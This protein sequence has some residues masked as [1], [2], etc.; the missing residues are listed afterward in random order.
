[1]KKLVYGAALAAALAAPALAN[2]ETD[3]ALNLGYE[4]ADYSSG[5]DYD[6]W[7]IGGVV[8]H[9]LSGG[10]TVQADGQTMLQQWNSGDYSHGYAAAHLST[11]LGGWDLGGFVGLLNYYGDGG[12]LFGVE[13]RT[14]FGNLSLDGALSF[15]DF[16]DNDYNA[17][18]LRV[19]GAYF[20][21]PN[22]AVTAGGARTDIDSFTDYEVTEYSVGAAYQFANNIALSGSYTD[23]DYEFY[24][25]D[26]IQLGLT[27]NFGG[28]SLQDNTNDGAWTSARHVSNTWSRW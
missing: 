19:G 23:A 24:D 2:A 15:S 28:G 18:A 8:T 26:A 6:G 25:V 10:M 17:T 21:M 12:T 14:A 13:T 7:T 20:F 11:D 16:G 27:F 5:S 9:D 3:G 22:F 4:N 1:M